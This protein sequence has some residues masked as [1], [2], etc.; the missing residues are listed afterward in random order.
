MILTIFFSTDKKNAI[1]D[2]DVKDDNMKAPPV[3]NDVIQLSMSF[4]KSKF[5]NITYDPILWLLN[6]LGDCKSSEV[7][8]DF[9]NNRYTVVAKYDAFRL[10]SQAQAV[11]F[12][13]NVCNHHLKRWKKSEE[14]DKWMAALSQQINE[15]QD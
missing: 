15:E 9:N 7:M 13:Q 4:H 14:R 2:I 6:R 3:N 1:T 12:A 11:G 10:P 8:I 5:E